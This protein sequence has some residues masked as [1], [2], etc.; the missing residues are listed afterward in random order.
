MIQ[1]SIDSDDPVL[2]FEP[3]R[4][5]W[6]KGE[7]DTA[8]APY[9]LHQARVLAP[10]TDATV[11]THGPLVATA[12]QAARIAGER[13]RSIEVIGSRVHFPRW[14]STQ[15]PHQPPALDG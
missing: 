15:S 1:Q 10:G 11:V 9:P 2:F 5:Y 14:T 12:L 3:K 7:I 8:A 4:R 13:G 6:D